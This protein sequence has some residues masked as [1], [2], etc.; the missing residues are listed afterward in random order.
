[1]TCP[2]LVF[3]KCGASQSYILKEKVLCLI[4]EVI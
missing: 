4:S 3:L 1:M 2:A